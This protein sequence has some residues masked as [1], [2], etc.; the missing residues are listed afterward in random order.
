MAL[1]ATFSSITIIIEAAMLEPTGI[2]PI[3][4]EAD[5]EDS[6]DHDPLIHDFF[7]KLCPSQIL[8]YGFFSL[9][10]PILVQVHHLR[11]QGVG[12]A[13]LHILSTLSTRV[14]WLHHPAWPPRVHEAPGLEMVRKENRDGI[15]EHWGQDLGR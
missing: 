12:P 14:A 13:Y 11:G 15:R 3:V 7:H 10:L 6:Q 8:L 5:V 4:R 1:P 2:L 9:V